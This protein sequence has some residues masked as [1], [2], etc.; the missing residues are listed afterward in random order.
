[1]LFGDILKLLFRE[2]SST[3]FKI[4]QDYFHLLLKICGV[5]NIL[6]GKYTVGWSNRFRLLLI[7]LLLLFGEM[8]ASLVVWK[9]PHDIE[10]LITSTITLILVFQVSCKFTEL[11]VHCESHREMLKTVEK[12]TE[13]LQSDPDYHHIG[14]SNYNRARFYVTVST[15]SYL[16]A[17][18]SLYLYPLYA[19]LINHEYKFLSNVELPGTKHKEPVGWMIN[20]IFGF[21]LG[22]F[23]GFLILGN[24]LHRKFCCTT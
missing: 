10:E 4:F 23:T 24:F 11:I 20:Y 18:V 17:L 9:Y 12:K 13:E 16:T 8:S 3:R 2:S 21:F 7:S 15:V 22:G 19:L 1:M 5:E 14:V 6:Q